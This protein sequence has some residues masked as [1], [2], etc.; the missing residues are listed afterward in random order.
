MADDDE[1][2]ELCNE[3]DVDGLRSFI[4]KCEAGYDFNQYEVRKEKIR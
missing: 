2:H 3:G 4:R 1:L